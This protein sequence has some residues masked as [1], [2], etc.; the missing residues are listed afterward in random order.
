[1]STLIVVAGRVPRLS[2]SISPE[3]LHGIEPNGSG[4]GDRGSE[5]ERGTT[6]HDTE[7]FRFTSSRS[8]RCTARFLTRS[9]HGEPRRTRSSSRGNRSAQI[10]AGSRRGGAIDERALGAKNS[11]FS[12]FLPAYSVLKI[13][14]G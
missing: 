8:C 6:R 14:L 9:K 5:H 4:S 13:S 3:K 2:G 12:D 11:V 1:M 10:M 7:R